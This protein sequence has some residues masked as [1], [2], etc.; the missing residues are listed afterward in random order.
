VQCFVIIFTCLVVYIV[1]T[2]GSNYFL[3]FQIVEGCKIAYGRF[4]SA[5]F[6]K[7]LNH[8]W[9]TMCPSEFRLHYFWP[10]CTFC[11]RL[12]ELWMP[13]GWVGG[14]RTFSNRIPT[15]CNQL[16]L[17]LKVDILQTLHICCGHI[18]DVHVTLEL[19]RHFSKKLHV[20]EWLIIYCFTSSS[21]IFHLYGDVTITGEWTYCHFSSIFWL[22]G[23]YI[24]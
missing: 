15:L 11:I 20:V 8:L 19:F 23:S 24:V 7:D 12:I 3:C 10:G 17:H 9:K 21:R 4:S 16:L 18:E 5:L 6:F 14:E 1:G 2:G 13:G 22:G